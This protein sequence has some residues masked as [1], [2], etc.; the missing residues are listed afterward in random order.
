MTEYYKYPR[1]Y[2]LPWSEGLTTDD[3]RIEH[4]DLFLGQRVIVTEKI[5]GENTSLYPDHLH[6]RSLDSKHHPSRNCIKQLHGEICFNIPEHNRLC[7]EN[8]FA[9]HSIFYD[10]LPAY[11]LLFS[12]WTDK[13]C[14]SWDDT[15]EWA[16]LLGLHTVP[17]LYDG[18]WDEAKV[19]S[20]WTG[21]SAYGPDQEGYVVRLAREFHFDEFSKCVTKFVRENHVQTS[22]HWLNEKIIPNLLATK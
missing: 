6:A 1:T 14:W 16:L 8:V 21:V 18:I 13:I 5:D 12:M 7:G 2:H 17:V 22:E 9:K 11:F 20:C 15:V 19:K 4:L 3:K 10:K